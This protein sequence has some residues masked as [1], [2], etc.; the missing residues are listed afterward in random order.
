MYP[1]QLNLKDR[2]VVIIGG[3]KIAWRKFSKLVTEPCTIDVVSPEFHE[4]FETV[5]STER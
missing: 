2:H 3:G 5:Q 4:A 1:V